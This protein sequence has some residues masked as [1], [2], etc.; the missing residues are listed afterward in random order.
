MN[1]R[2]K[3]GIILIV[4]SVVLYFAGYF[5]LVEHAPNP[6]TNTSNFLNNMLLAFF[7]LLIGVIIMG[8]GAELLTVGDD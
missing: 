1:L 2:Q 7:L 5:F 4:F 3:V 6:F 8:T